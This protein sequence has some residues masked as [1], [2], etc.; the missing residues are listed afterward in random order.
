MV[1]C[2][3][4]FETEV[5]SKGDVNGNS[6]TSEMIELIVERIEKQGSVLP[7]LIVKI[8]EIT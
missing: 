3:C 6:R 4:I 2:F 5:W 1:L 7:T 8:C